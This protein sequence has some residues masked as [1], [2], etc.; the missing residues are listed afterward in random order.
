V[1][2]AAPSELRRASRRARRVDNMILMC[3]VSRPVSG[4]LTRQSTLAQWAQAWDRCTVAG[5]RLLNRVLCSMRRRINASAGLLQ[6]L[7]SQCSPA[8]TYMR[9]ASTRPALDTDLL[10]ASV[11]LALSVVTNS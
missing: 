8:L 10:T 4:Q 5:K 11:S 6:A 9:S 7:H 2:A 3:L 1:L